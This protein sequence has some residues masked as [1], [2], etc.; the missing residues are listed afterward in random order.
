L[1]TPF[2]QVTCDGTDAPIRHTTSLAGAAEA[3]VELL[4]D[5]HPD[6]TPASKRTAPTA[7]ADLVIFTARSP[8]PALSGQ[9]TRVGLRACVRGRYVVCVETNRKLSYKIE[10]VARLRQPR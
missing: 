10:F 5:E 4:L 9:T 1:T 2:I 3:D 7:A 6:A 8:F